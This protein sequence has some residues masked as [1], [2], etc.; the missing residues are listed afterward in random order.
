MSAFELAML[1]KAKRR[2]RIGHE[3]TMIENR[4]HISN[5]QRKEGKRKEKEENIPSEEMT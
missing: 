5:D 2:G 4:S 3:S 1:E